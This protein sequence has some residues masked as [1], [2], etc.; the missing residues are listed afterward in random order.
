MTDRFTVLIIL[1]LSMQSTLASEEALNAVPLPGN[2]TMEPIT[3]NLVQNGHRLSIANLEPRSSI[4]SV[5]EFYREQ[6]QEPLSENIPG[7]VENTAGSWSI[8]SRPRDGWN[9]V[10]QLRPASEGVEGRISVMEL[11]P[12]QS[13][14]AEISLP[15]GST[16]V[17]STG[18]QD[19]GH[20]SSTFVVFSESG[21]KA[22]ADHY[23]RDFD[24]TGWS[25]VSD[26]NILNSTVLLMQKEGE[27][28]EIVV[29]SIDGGALAI[30][31]KVIDDD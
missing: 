14:L 19:I 31:N 25:R 3:L 24:N 16:L 1:A 17:S 7:F 2:A 4:E 8:I 5:L 13:A 10:V 11:E 27:R 28:A 12:A 30:I 26:K 15:S 29:S 9:Q 22:V 21:V 18:A 6:W 20:A 23:R